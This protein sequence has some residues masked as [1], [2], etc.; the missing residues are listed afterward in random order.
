[1]LAVANN[2]GGVAKTTSVL[3]LGMAL[4]QRG[5]RVL[6][7]D[8]D[9]QAS[10]SSALPLP[11]ARPKPPKNAPVPVREQ[12]I[13]QY[14]T[15]QI[16]RLSDLVQPTRFTNVFVMPAS[17]EL[18][19]LDTGGG[20]RTAAEL[21]FV[22]DIHSADLTPAVAGGGLVPF[23]WILLDTPPAQ[24]FFTRL[25]LA[26]AH[27]VLIPIHIEAFGTYGINRVLATADTMR[28]LTG[29][30]VH[31]VGCLPTRWKETRGSKAAM[32]KLKS[33]LPL[34]HTRLFHQDIPYHDGIEQAHQTTIGGG[35]KN[36]F[37][38]ANNVAAVAYNAALDEFIQE[39]QP[40]VHQ[41]RQ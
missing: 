19:R 31:V 38:F 3:N 1:M 33:D 32:A 13:S 14:F 34:Q 29:Q 17:D 27:Y 21:A 5:E 18:H 23:D 12:F 11:D 41:P 35:I 28:A 9:G 30:G 8:M 4:A 26:A 6:L 36:L 7:V 15:G 16:Q 25:A 40:N 20:A 24:S 2:K 22:Q 37:G 10:L 39:V